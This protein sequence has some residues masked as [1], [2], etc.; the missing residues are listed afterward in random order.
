VRAPSHARP[1]RLTPAQ[2]PRFLD[3]MYGRERAAAPLT[4]GGNMRA[5]VRGELG[6]QRA[7]R[8]YASDAEMAHT[9]A[10]MR[11]M[12]GP[13]CY[14]RTTD[15]RF[16]EEQGACA[17]CAAAASELTQTRR[18]EANLIARVPLP[19][20]LPVLFVYGTRDAT[21]TPEKLPG[22]RAALPRC[23]EVRLD[24]I[25]H[26]VMLQARDVVTRA[27]LGFLEEE[28][29]LEARGRL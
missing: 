15:A 16:A 20:T 19:A 18:A 7:S 13:L 25:G 14:Y 22:A 5:Y 3:V 11:D 8:P 1:A 28:G 26:W 17:L 12:H 10:Q 29:V 27:V 23:R 24:G 6:S 2:L 9:A 4:E 21:A